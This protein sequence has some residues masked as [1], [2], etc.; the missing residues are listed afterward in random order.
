MQSKA[1]MCLTV[2]QKLQPTLKEFRCAPVDL[3]NDFLTELGW[4]HDLEHSDI[5]RAVR[6][7]TGD[8]YT[9]CDDNFE[10]CVHSRRPC[11]VYLHPSR[12]KQESKKGY[13]GWMHSIANAWLRKADNFKAQM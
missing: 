12:V 9:A 1:S 5:A 13:H 7:Y 6:V 8:E 11:K 2:V 10:P 3:I 4:Q